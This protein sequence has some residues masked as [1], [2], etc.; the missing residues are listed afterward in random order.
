MVQCLLA[1]PFLVTGRM[2]S[3]QVL[4]PSHGAMADVRAG[5]LGCSSGDGWALVV[6][7]AVAALGLFT[8]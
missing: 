8:R 6:A 7:A 1:C 5:G 2:V 4:R 3:M